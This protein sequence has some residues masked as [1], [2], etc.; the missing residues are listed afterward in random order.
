MDLPNTLINQ[1]TTFTVTTVSVA[2]VI[3]LLWRRIMKDNTEVAKDRAEINIIEVMQSQIATL[4]AENLRLRNTESELSNR[5]GRLEAKEQEVDA[6][7]DKI[8]K[9]QIKLDEKDQKIENLLITHAEATA[10]LK[11]QLE[12]KEDQIRELMIR[13]EDLERRMTLSRKDD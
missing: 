4:S 8:E 3:R 5:L 12:R 9:L 7:V 11:Y 6:Y 1:A 13:I 10:T 2:W